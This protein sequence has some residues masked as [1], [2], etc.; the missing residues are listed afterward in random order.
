LGKA[1]T[2]DLTTSR[3]ANNTNQ[4]DG[5]SASFYFT[6]SSV[7]R[8][9]CYSIY[10]TLAGELIKSTATPFRCSTMLHSNKGFDSTASASIV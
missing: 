6:S 1:M 3:S 9:P 10:A 5:S 8:P 7:M 4:S 2:H